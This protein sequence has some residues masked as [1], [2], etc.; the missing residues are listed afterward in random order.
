LPNGR[1]PERHFP[2]ALPAKLSQ[3]RFLFVHPFRR[4]R[5]D[6]IQHLGNRS[7][8]RQ[9]RQQV[10]MIGHSA[11]LQQRALL[12]ANDFADVSIQI[13]S[14][15]RGNERESVLRT[16]DEMIEQVG[17]RSGHLINLPHATYARSGLGL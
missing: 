4:L 3:F 16:E 6:P 17:V 10:N 13:A 11:N 14:Q 5:L 12:A 9:F 7:A 8:R 2:A 1:L 15:R